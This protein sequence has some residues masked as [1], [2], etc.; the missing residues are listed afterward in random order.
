MKFQFFQNKFDTNTLKLLPKIKKKNYKIRG[1]IYFQ[2]N[3]NHKKVFYE[4]Q[5]Q[6]RFNFFYM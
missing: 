2:M 6:A 4:I 3:K 5:T 1:V